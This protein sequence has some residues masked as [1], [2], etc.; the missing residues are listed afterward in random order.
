MSEDNNAGN[1]NK[2]TPTKKKSGQASKPN[3]IVEK[4]GE[5]KSEFNKIVWPSRPTLVKQSFT[6][7][8]ISLL[9]G[10]YISGLDIVLGRLFSMFIG[11]FN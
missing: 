6:V 1:D 9:F 11:L 8:V 2:A 4:F 10:A 5:F 7:I 3:F